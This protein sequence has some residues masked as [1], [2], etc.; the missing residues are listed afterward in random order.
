ME[1]S[2]AWSATRA[3]IPRY[4][5]L[6]TTGAVN[7]NGMITSSHALTDINHAIEAARARQG[8]R[9]TVRF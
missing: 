2:W 4:A 3:D 8:V 9:A 7:V 1:P 6:V 5:E